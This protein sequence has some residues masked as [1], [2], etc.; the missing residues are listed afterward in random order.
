MKIC[1]G[2]KNSHEP[3]FF[4]SFINYFATQGHEQFIIA[5]DYI[6]V[7]SLLEQLKLPYMSIG[8]HYGGNKLMK[9]IGLIINDFLIA[10]NAPIFDVSIS[11]ANTY[12]IHASKLRNKKAITLTDNDIS[13]NLRTYNKIVD[14]LITPAAI[15]KKQLLRRGCLE[16]TIYQY[17][18]FKEDIYI[19]DYE[20][21]KTFLEK[22]PIKDFVT[23]RAESVNAHYIPKDTKSLAPELFRAFEKNKLP[24]LF[25]PRYKSDREYAAGFDNVYMPEKPLNGLDVCFYSRAVLTGAGTF[26]REA[27]IIGTPAVSFFPRD[28]LLAVDRKMVEDGWMFHSRDPESIVDY[29]LSSAKK[30]FDAERSK[31]VQKE[32]FNI[33]ENILLEIE[34]TLLS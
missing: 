12:L 14:Y 4:K 28:D 10:K 2:I 31:N 27:A 34:K 23:V 18:G 13:F 22:L 16:K 32:L 1:Y 21:D 33:L 17:N 30:D 5:R 8:K 24:V 7:Q 3:N 9:F 20:P 26:A 25:L 19:A 29:V 6:E 11:H 15:P